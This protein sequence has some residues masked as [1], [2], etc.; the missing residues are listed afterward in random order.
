MKV[1]DAFEEIFH[2]AR[3]NSNIFSGKGDFGARQQFHSP[4]ASSKGVHF[5]EDLYASPTD[6]SDLALRHRISM[7]NGHRSGPALAETSFR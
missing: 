6:H 1:G 5:L 2:E 3:G 7:C 4:R